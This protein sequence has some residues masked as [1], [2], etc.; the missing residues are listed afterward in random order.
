MNLGRRLAAGGLGSVLLAATVVGSGIMAERLAAGDV[1]IV[2]LA[3]TG[4]TVAV[5]AVLIA[6]LAPTSGA[7][8]NPAVSFIETLRGRLPWTYFGTY[9]AVQIAGC[10]AAA[11]LAHDMFEL[12]LLQAS[13]HIRTG[14]AQ[15]L[16]EGVATC[17][18]VLV[19]VGTATEAAREQLRPGEIQYE[20][21]D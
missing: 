16:A 15:W 14:G 10:C 8:F 17:G 18:L 11:L 5:L 2:L 19:V 7:H 1:A 6:L 3:N 12:P 21:R 13:G 4:V 20:G 9:A